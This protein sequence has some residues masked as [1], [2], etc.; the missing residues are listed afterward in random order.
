MA[1][2]MLRLA[3][4]P[5]LA[6]DLGVAARQRIESHFSEKLSDRRLWAVIEPCLAPA[7]V[8]TEGSTLLPRPCSPQLTP[9]CE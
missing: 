1:A 7:R 9:D 4:D 2:H 6:R 3:Q 5:E 8:S